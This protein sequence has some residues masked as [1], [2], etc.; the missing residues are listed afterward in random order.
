MDQRLGHSLA[1]DPALLHQAGEMLEGAIVRPLSVGREH[2]SGELSASQV[3][4][5]AVAAHALA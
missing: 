4:G 2:A 1:L 5:E 3:I